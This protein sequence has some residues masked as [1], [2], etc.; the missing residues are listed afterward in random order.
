MGQIH[1]TA[2]LESHAGIEETFLIYICV[3]GAATLKADGEVFRFAE[4]ELVLVPAECSEFVL[5]PEGD[6]A[7]VLEVRMDPRASDDIVSEPV[8]E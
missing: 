6:A 8:E 2:P 4:G 1:L 7:V 3:G 5:A